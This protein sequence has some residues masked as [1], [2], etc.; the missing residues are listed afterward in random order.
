MSKIFHIVKRL[1][2]W[3]KL[4]DARDLFVFAG[5]ALLYA[6]ISGHWDRYVAMIVIGSIILAKGLIKWV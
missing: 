5:F 4:F 6:G 1:L 2:R 3:V